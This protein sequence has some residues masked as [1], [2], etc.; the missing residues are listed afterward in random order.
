M[1]P[2]SLN[3]GEWVF[4]GSSRLWTRMG[5]CGIATCLEPFVN[6]SEDSS[7][8]LRCPAGLFPGLERCPHS[9]RCLATRRPP[10]A[11]RARGGIMSRIVP[12]DDVIRTRDER[13]SGTSWTSRRRNVMP[14]E[15]D[16][17]SRR[18]FSATFLARRSSSLNQCR[19]RQ[20]SVTLL[21]TT[22]SIAF[23]YE[24]GAGGSGV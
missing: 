8:R 11:T 10:R 17:R 7:L 23:Q 24:G 12:P 3:R 14:C 6:E 4:G 19:L 1:F 18:P 20:C 15:L 22:R 21:A 9:S 2:A 16:V 5:D 13:S